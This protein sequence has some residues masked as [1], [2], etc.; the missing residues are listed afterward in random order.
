MKNKDGYVDDWQIRTYKDCHP[1][2]AVRVY[3]EEECKERIKRAILNQAEFDYS[4]HTDCIDKGRKE[5]LKELE[6]YIKKYPRTFI[7]QVK[8]DCIELEISY[9]D[10]N[11]LINKIKEML[12][13]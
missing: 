9:I 12:N 5:A 1:S 10:V 6:E 3:A 2:S 7:R 4:H 11:D 8:Y 13:E